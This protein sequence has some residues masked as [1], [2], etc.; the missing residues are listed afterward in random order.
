M[1]PAKIKHILELTAPTDEL[2]YKIVE[3]IMLPAILN[4]L[5][6]TIPDF[7]EI[8]E[9]SEAIKLYPDYAMDWRK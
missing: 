7:I 3:W 9:Q 1:K 2:L 8:W 5:S 4:E 6:R